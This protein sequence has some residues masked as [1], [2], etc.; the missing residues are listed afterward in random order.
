M[1]LKKIRQINKKAAHERKRKQVRATIHKT[2]REMK[3][4]RNQFFRQRRAHIAQREA[5]S[6][7][8]SSLAGE[9]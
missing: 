1:A 3:A 8:I 9:L 4:K 5:E 2:N 6:D 7:Y